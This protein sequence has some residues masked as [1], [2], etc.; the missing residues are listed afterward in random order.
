MKKLLITLFAL[1]SMASLA[2]ATGM[3]TG[4]KMNGNKKYCYYTDGTVITIEYTGMC[5]MSIQAWESI[6]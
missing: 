5:P 1:A 4:E 2:Y 3:Y 6:T